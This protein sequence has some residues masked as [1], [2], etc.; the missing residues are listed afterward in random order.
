MKTLA[1]HILPAVAC[2][3]LL[4]AG[5]GCGDTPPGTSPAAPTPLNSVDSARDVPATDT[6]S[7]DGVG[8]DDFPAHLDRDFYRRLVF[9]SAEAIGPDQLSPTS[10]VL[11]NPGS[12][13]FVF[14]RGDVAGECEVG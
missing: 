3:S 4:A 10:M 12:M 8:A 2:A 14:F 13:N 5:V 11:A 6:S 7:L 9:N 1:K